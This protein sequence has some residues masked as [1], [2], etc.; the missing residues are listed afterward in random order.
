MTLARSEFKL[1]YFGSIL[2]YVW[3]LMR[4]LLF[5]GVIYLFFVKIIGVGAGVPH[6]GLYLLTGIVL[7]NYFA[8]ATGNCVSCLVVRESMLRKVRFPRMVVPL[9]VSLTASFNLGMNFIVV[10]LFALG[11]EITPT[12]KWLEMVPIILCF[13][14]FATGIGMLLSALYVRFRDMQPIWEV[15]Q[16]AWFYG[17]PVMY[18][19]SRYN[20]FAPNFEHIAMLNPVATLLTQMGHAFIDPKSFPSAATAAGG[21]GPVIIALALIPATFA[22][23]WWVFTRE[24]PRVAENL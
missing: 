16:L 11:S 23:G 3:S 20:K 19:A 14:I 15:T 10:I 2:G 7:W 22:L 4:P 1:R 5:F 6:Y 9:S 13:I 24:A 17:S 12:A 8:E 21:Y 18:P